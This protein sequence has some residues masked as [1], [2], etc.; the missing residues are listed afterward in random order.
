MVHFTRFI[1]NEIMD[2]ADTIDQLNDRSTIQSHE[3]AEIR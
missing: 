2:V 1:K 3:I